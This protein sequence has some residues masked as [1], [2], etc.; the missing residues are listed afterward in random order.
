[1]KMR[2]FITACLLLLAYPLFAQEDST[3]RIK[4][5]DPMPSFTIYQADS[6]TIQSDGLKGKVVLVNFFA[7]WC[8]PCQVELAKVQSS[9]WPAYK[10][11]S[12]F[13][14]L[15][16]GREHDAEELSKYNEK[17]GFTF[18]LYPDKDRAIYSL[19]AEKMIPRTYLIGKDGRVIS[20]SM[21]FKEAEFTELMEQISAALK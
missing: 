16:I 6:T 4:V 7:T 17:K 15:V 20:L 18:P 10:D 12:D 3:T 2:L 13:R 1:M 21:G 8:P 11:R 5:G 14:L 9:L 19:F